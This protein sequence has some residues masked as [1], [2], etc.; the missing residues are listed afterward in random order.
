MHPLRHSI[1]V[2]SES[3]QSFSRDEK[4]R[5]EKPQYLPATCMPDDAGALSSQNP[6]SLKHGD[7]SHDRE[8]G[9]RVKPP[10][11]NDCREKGMFLLSTNRK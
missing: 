2:C 3:I 8:A 5:A 10:L 6:F 1:Y 4:S 7:H 11:S 9:E